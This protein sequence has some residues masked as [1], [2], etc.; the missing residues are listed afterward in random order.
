MSNAYQD[1]QTDSQTAIK[2]LDF[3]NSHNG[4]IQQ[5]VL[6]NAISARLPKNLG[7]RI[8]DAGCG[9]G[10]LCG[11]LKKDFKNIE[12]CDSS[13][14]LIKFAKTHYPGPDFKVVELGK[15]LPYPQNNFDFVIINMVGPDLNRLDL[16]FANVAA[17]LKPSGK[18]LMTVPNPEFTYPAAEW[19]RGALRFI[20]RQKPK[21]I[22]KQPP[23]GGQKISREFG[24]NYKIA[25]YYYTL[26]NYISACQK[27]G[28]SFKQ[29]QELPEAA[30]SQKFDLNYQLSLYP[31]LLLL[32]FEKPL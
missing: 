22:K 1:S 7:L 20:L 5:Q 27:A 17:V 26:D 12:A 19:K 13:D 18:L 4:Q 21:L 2:Y 11:M 9:S 24:G 32:E 10:W 25:S 29:K 6:F 30:Q 15:L 14:F 3:L 23:V 16:A 8:L 31:L 28:L